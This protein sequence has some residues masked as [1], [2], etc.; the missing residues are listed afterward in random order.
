MEDLIERITALIRIQEID[1][2]LSRSVKW[3]NWSHNQKVD[4]LVAEREYLL[5]KYHI[6]EHGFDI[7]K[8]AVINITINL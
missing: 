5:D 8:P 6:C 1:K 3:E 2:E 4:R 7:G